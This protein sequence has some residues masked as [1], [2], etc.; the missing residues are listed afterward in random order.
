MTLYFSVS[1]DQDHICA[2]T[3]D[4]SNVNR[5]G[6][7]EVEGLERLFVINIAEKTVKNVIEVPVFVSVLKL[8]YPSM[9]ICGHF[10]GNVTVWNLE[11]GE[12]IVNLRGHTAD[13]LSL[14]FNKVSLRLSNLQFLP[15]FR[16]TNLFLKLITF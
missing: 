15:K 4:P 11:T 14:D 1:Y 9:V 7:N 8:I 10:D 3:S 12:N 5:L 13:V 2:A 6:T 16:K